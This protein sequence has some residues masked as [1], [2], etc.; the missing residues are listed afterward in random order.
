MP[1]FDLRR[2]DAWQAA[3]YHTQANGTGTDGTP[4]M[5]HDGLFGGFQ[6]GGAGSGRAGRWGGREAK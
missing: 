4:Y 2:G 5:S 6:V 3:P 1:Y